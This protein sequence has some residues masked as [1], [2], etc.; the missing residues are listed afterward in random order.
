MGTRRLH[1]HQ[2]ALGR[3]APG[4]VPSGGAWYGGADG[5]VRAS[6]IWILLTVEASCFCYYE[7]LVIHCD[8]IRTH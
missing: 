2:H 7:E 3:A 5:N 8:F 1:G 4:L 6:S